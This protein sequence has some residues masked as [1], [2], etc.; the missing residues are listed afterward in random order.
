MSSTLALSETMLFSTV[1]AVAD[2][3]ESSDEDVVE[4][5]G[6]FSREDVLATIED[7]VRAGYLRRT[8]VLLLDLTNEGA[9][10]V[11]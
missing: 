10:L 8:G 6:G 9:D 11:F 5:L 1:D 3:G 2:L 7:A 4:Y